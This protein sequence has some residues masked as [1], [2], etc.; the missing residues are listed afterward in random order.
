MENSLQKK[1]SDL[2][3]EWSVRNLPITPDD[4][5]YGTHKLFWWKGKCGHEWQAS[6]HSR[7]GKNNSGCPYCS[8]NKILPGF[9]DLASRFPEVAA[10]WSDK[11]LPLTPDQ[12]SPF[13]NKKAWWKGKCGHEWYALISSR[14]DGH[15]CPYCKDHKVL[16]G[17]N[18]FGTMHPELAKEW[19]ERNLPLT[20]D[21]LPEK[22]TG[23]FWWKCPDCGEEY[24]AWIQSRISGGKCPYCS[25]RKVKPGLNDLLT[26][27]PGIAAEW[28]YERNGDIT[29]K[30]IF[31][32]SRKI[33]WWKC[34]H[35]HSWQ[36]KVSERTIDKIPCRKC[37]EEFLRNLPQLLILLYARMKQIRV[38]F[39]SD[40]LAG[41]PVEILIPE[42][43]LAI[44]RPS[45]KKDLTIQQKVKQHVLK[46]HGFDY[47]IFQAG[48]TAEMIAGQIRDL[49]RTRHIYFNHSIVEDIR[50][51]RKQFEILR[52]K[53]SESA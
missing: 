36:A 35:G 28:D 30:Q 49:Y 27:D 51:C 9:N 47:V 22:K 21:K 12:V 24:K 4:I 32:T 33:Y 34:P 18:D 37:E 10:E 15:G 43:H 1:R 48:N 45:E 31:R 53:E 20:P 6:P 39:G 8:G 11:N 29:P 16:T 42:L 3:D 25:G 7:T 40:E 23:M 14:S 19:S 2:A 50:I 46:T 38:L 44:E 13:S 26:T 17:F 41:V 5:S 52:R